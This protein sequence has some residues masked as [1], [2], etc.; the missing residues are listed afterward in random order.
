M[1]NLINLFKRDLTALRFTAGC[2]SFALSIGFFVSATDTENYDLM[3]SIF[4]QHIWGLLFL[5]YASV[6][7]YTCIAD[8]LHKIIIPNSIFGIWIWSYLFFSFAIFDKTP[9]KST[10]WMLLIPILVEIW[11]FFR[12]IIVGKICKK[13]NSD[14][15]KVLSIITD[16]VESINLEVTKL[17]TENQRLNKEVGY[18]SSEV[19]K[20]RQQLILSQEK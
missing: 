10:E 17:S 1:N 12:E 16:Q 15:Q 7:L 11:V 18:L 2:L 13:E 20:L 3:N 19:S 6:H 4:D 8:K 14:F 5:S 9:I